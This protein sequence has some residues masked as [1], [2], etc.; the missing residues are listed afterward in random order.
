VFPIRPGET[1]FQISYHTNYSGSFDFKPQILTK[2]DDVVEMLPKQMQFKGDQTDFSSG[3]EE[4]GLNIYVAH[5]VAAGKQLAYSISGTGEIPREA[6]ADGE[7][8][9]AQSASNAPDN[10]PGGGLGR[11]EESPDALH[12]YKWWILGGL[13][14]AL[15]V[16]AIVVINQKPRGA[17]PAPG[18]AVLSTPSGRASVAGSS[19]SNRNLLLEAMKEELFQLETD[20]LQGK[21]SETEYQ[22]AKAALD[23]TMKRALNRSSQQARA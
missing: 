8:G 23:L 20:R 14:A 1:K 3:G 11:P 10:R 9:G 4:K 21:I 19:I 17:T 13:A 15:V 18:A 16:G 7:N 22:Q 2:T 6:Q 12:A 5:N